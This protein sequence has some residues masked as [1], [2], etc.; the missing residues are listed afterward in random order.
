MSEGLAF[1]SMLRAEEMQRAETN[2][3]FERYAE[4]ECD[5]VLKT[6]LEHLDECEKKIAGHLKEARFHIKRAM[7]K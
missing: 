7:T 1:S 3:Q 6:A 4:M 2:R 5:A